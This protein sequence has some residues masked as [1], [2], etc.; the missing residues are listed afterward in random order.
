MR[1]W[2][3][4]SC[5]P[6]L[7][8]HQTR[9]CESGEHE[10]EE[11][12]CYGTGASGVREGCAGGVADGNVCTDSS[13]IASV[14][15]PVDGLAILGCHNLTD[16]H[17]FGCVAGNR[18][19]N[20]GAARVYEHNSRFNGVFGNPVPKEKPATE[21]TDF[22]KNLVLNQSPSPPQQYSRSKDQ[23]SAGDCKEACTGTAGGR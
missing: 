8:H 1:F 18:L 9:A 5:F 11:V 14:S 23:E 13:V 3:I 22:S 17:Q 15:I 7:P 6:S 21:V 2:K 19:A 16:F 20:I 12:E 4:S 10:T